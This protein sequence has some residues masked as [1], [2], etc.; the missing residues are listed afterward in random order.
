M[1]MEKVILSNLIQNEDYARKVITYLKLEYFQNL[2]DQ[3]MYVT[4]KGYIEKYNGVPEIQSLRAQIEQDN[5]P[6]SIYDDSKEFL[7]QMEEPLKNSDW[8]VDETEKFCQER[9]IYN[10]IHKSSEIMED[11]DKKLGK[12]SIPEL[13]S[14]ALG[15]TFDNRVGH[16]YFQQYEERHDY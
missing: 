4:T 8:L 16:D 12:G 9:A 10:A 6:E 7:V 15:V 2:S 3:Y 1:M 5:I 14:D 13:L 11:N